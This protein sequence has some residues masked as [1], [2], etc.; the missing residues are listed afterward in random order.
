IGEGEKDRGQYED[1]KQVNYLQGSCLMVKREVTQRIG[2]LDST[3]FAYWE[4]TDWCVRGHR[5]GFKSVF[6]PEAKIWHKV[7]ASS[8]GARSTYYKTRNLFWFM[9]KHATGK[10][11]LCFTLYF[12]F[13]QFWI[14]SGKIIV[15]THSG[16]L[17]RSFLKGVRDGVR[18][19]NG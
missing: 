11:F 13:V 8:G 19:H 10:Q 4:E 2:L 14:S 16:D 3:F 15:G 1:T 6:V 12:F 5:A 9:K 17:L 18:N 7:E